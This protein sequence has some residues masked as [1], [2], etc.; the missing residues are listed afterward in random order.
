MSFNLVWHAFTKWRDISLL[1]IDSK[2]IINKFYSKQKS[3]KNENITLILIQ[4][5][6]FSKG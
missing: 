3:N 2:K 5:L 1:K 6:K 4:L